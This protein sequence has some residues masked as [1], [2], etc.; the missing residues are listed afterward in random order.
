MAWRRRK[1]CYN[2]WQVLKGEGEGREAERMG[3]LGEHEH[4]MRSEE[5]GGE[6]ARWRAR[7][8]GRHESC[9]SE[10]R[11]GRREFNQTN[12]RSERREHETWIKIATREKA[13]WCLVEVDRGRKLKGEARS[14]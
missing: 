7:R 13:F 2:A 4:G 3:R 11:N 14:K 5:D 1:G 12:K 6:K 10:G 9:E 8:R